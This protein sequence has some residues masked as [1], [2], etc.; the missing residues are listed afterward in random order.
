M[1]TLSEEIDDDSHFLF[2]PNFRIA[3]SKCDYI[4]KNDTFKLQHSKS[5]LW[6][7]YNISEFENEK[8]NE[9]INFRP[10]ML[11]TGY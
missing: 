1:L 11:N 2:A 10:K 3:N 8:S 9:E 7:G 5:K 4:S 6:V